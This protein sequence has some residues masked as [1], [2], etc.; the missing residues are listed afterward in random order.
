MNDDMKW[1]MLLAILFIGTP[2]VGLALTDYQHSQC[3]IE[4]IKAGVDADK[5]NAACGVK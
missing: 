3:R 2:L 4:A 1:V 5:I